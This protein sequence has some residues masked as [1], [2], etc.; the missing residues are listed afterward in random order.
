MAEQW[1]EGVLQRVLLAPWQPLDYAAVA[2]EER[3]E[4]SAGG[5]V[6]EYGEVER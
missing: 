5:S 6:A 2:S 4:R 3:L 1:S